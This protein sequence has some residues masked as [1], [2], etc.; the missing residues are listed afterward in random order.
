M[1]NH[2][3]FSIDNLVRTKLSYMGNIQGKHV[4]AV[5]TPTLNTPP[6]D[7]ANPMEWLTNPVGL[8]ITPRYNVTWAESGE[9]VSPVKKLHAAALV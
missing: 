1:K 3:A 4:A 9:I 8:D 6:S 7:D 5:G 2:R